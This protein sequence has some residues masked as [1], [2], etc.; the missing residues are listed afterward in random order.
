MRT[1]R[2]LGSVGPGACLPGTRGLLG[3]GSGAGCRGLSRVRF[4]RPTM[5]S[6]RHPPCLARKRFKASG[7]MLQFLRKHAGPWGLAAEPPGPHWAPEL[8]AAAGVGKTTD[9]FPV[10][11]SG[12]Q[13]DDRG[14]RGGACGLTRGDRGQAPLT[15]DALNTLSDL[16]LQRYSRPPQSLPLDVCPDLIRG[17]LSSRFKPTLRPEGSPERV[18]ATAPVSSGADGF[19]RGASKCWGA[20]DGQTRNLGI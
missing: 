12:T 17:P 18:L 20:G 5:A 9:A 4:T 6:R 7:V 13:K 15:P 3:L 16:G 8:K 14:Q 11:P 10:M 1:C 19:P 2:R